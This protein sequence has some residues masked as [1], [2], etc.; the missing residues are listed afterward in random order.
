MESCTR[1]ANN[2][3]RAVLKCMSMTIRNQNQQSVCPNLSVR[4]TTRDTHMLMDIN[5]SQFPRRMKTNSKYLTEY[6]GAKTR[7]IF[8]LGKMVPSAIQNGHAQDIFITTVNVSRG[9]LVET[10]IMK[11]QKET[12][13]CPLICVIPY[14]CFRLIKMLIISSAFPSVNAWKITDT[15]SPMETIKNV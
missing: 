4:I 14:L 12:N 5:V 13:A 3:F 6:I 9:K 2:L 1:S 8:L 15:Y 10:T 11:L 7:N